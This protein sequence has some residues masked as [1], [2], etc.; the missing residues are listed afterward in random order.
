[1]TL[2]TPLFKFLGEKKKRFPEEDLALILFPRRH[3]SMVAQMVK[4][5]PGMQET[6]A[7]FWVGRSL[8]EGMAAH[9]SIFA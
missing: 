8:E 9:S 4:G 7:D 6:R 5:P 2:F 1:M 3:N